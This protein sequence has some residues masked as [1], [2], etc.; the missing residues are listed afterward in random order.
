[1]ERI[2]RVGNSAILS[3]LA[4]KGVK[5]GKD[6]E[7][8][9]SMNVVPDTV[10]GRKEE[11]KKVRVEE[12]KLKREMKAANV[13]QDNVME[14]KESVKDV[15][16]RLSDLIAW[17]R[18]DCSV[19]ELVI[20]AKCCHWRVK[21]VD[22]GRFVSLRVF[23][24]E[25][26]CFENVEEVKLIGLSKLERVV[27][28]QKSFTKRKNGWPTKA[29]DRHFYLKN[30]ERLRELKI[31][32]NSFSDYSVCEIENVP[33]LEVIEM[34]DLG[35]GSNNFEYASLELK[36][37]SERIELMTRLAQFEITSVW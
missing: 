12:E 25:D 2:R 1:M 35:G 21:E 33:S 11:E 27:I 3:K 14:K 22:L 34:G 4:K 10:V 26:E 16:V 23:E 37:D 15:R 31:G 17:K 9:E 24:V 36:S 6:E 32:Y 30:C 7:G 8:M 20:A 18:M 5:E 29:P 13:V 28:G 19:T